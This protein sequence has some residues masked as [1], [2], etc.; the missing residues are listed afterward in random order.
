LKEEEKLEEKLV[1]N[2]V[3]EHNFEVLGICGRNP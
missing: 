2:Q 3:I 1:R